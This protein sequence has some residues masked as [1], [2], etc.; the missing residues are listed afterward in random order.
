MAQR[1]EVTLGFVREDGRIYFVSRRGHLESVRAGRRG[2]KSRIEVKLGIKKDKK[3]LYFL[4]R[5]GDVSS[6]PLARR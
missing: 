5:A 2:G 6:A 1:K 4:D 3:R